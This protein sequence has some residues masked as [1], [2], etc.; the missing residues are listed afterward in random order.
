MQAHYKLGCANNL[1]TK[2]LIGF[3]A[4]AITLMY[5]LPYSLTCPDFRISGRNI[6]F[7]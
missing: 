4:A 1:A 3:V 6:D 7:A 5:L 2:R